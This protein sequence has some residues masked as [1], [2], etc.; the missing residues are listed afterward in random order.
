[1]ETEMDANL[2]EEI[3]AEAARSGI[4]EA[5]AWHVVMTRRMQPGRIV[6]LSAD[7][8]DGHWVTIDGNH[9]FI[10]GP[11]MDA[12]VRREVESAKSAAAKF[13]TTPG[14][15]VRGIRKSSVDMLGRLPSHETQARSFHEKMVKHTEKVLKAMGE[16]WD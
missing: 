10:K 14:N 2:Q 5:M 11:E 6:T 16:K 12:H 1:M 4:S 15:Y 13:N 3:R 9:V 8:G 7:D